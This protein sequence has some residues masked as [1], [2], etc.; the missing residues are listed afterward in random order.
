MVILPQINKTTLEKSEN[1]EKNSYKSEPGYNFNTKFF[2]FFL[3][4]FFMFFFFFFE[5]TLEG[6]VFE[7][8]EKNPSK[9]HYQT[10]ITLVIRQYVKYEI[11]EG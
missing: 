9:L 2:F 1:P 3:K 10:L 7:N 11:L 5:I 4:S 8:L 6:K